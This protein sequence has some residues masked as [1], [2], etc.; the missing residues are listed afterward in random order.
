VKKTKRLPP[1]FKSWRL[2]R[3]RLIIEVAPE[4]LALVGKDGY[5]TTLPLP[6]PTNVAA[7][8]LVLMIYGWDRKWPNLELDCSAYAR[9]AGIG[10]WHRKRRLRSGTQEA[11]QW[12]RG[13]SGKLDITFKRQTMELKVTA[14]PK[15]DMPKSSSSDQAEYAEYCAKLEAA[16]EVAEREMEEAAHWYDEQAQTRRSRNGNGHASN[17]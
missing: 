2:E 3:A 5:W 10:R 16:Q 17:G 1:P 13:Q 6:L 15:V 4:W 12:F 7:K 8:N 11:E 14:A 9:K